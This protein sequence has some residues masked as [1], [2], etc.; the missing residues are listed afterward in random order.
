VAVVTQLSLERYGFVTLS[1]QAEIVM[2]TAI[3]QNP[4]LAPS[5]EARMGL[6]ARGAT[7]ERIGPIELPTDLR[8]WATRSTLLV[9][10]DLELTSLDAAM[11]GLG[12]RLRPHGEYRP[13]IL[14]RLLSLAYAM[15][16]FSSEEIVRL[17]HAD[18][19]FRRL[20]EETVP[21]RHELANFRRRNRALLE[22]LLAGVFL[23][24]LRERFDLDGTVLPLEM[25]RDLE[26]RAV[27]RLDI[28]RH[29]DN[30]VE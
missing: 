13:R 30:A 21:F 22:K 15:S 2:Q 7:S 11:P 1:S 9:W 24:G 25:D 20:C 14:L 8:E 10:I 5:D 18:S 4:A 28:A 3:R 26:E 16:V 29:M 12:Q 27:T 6:G 17:C 23:R 19:F